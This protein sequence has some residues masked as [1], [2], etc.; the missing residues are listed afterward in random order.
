MCAVYQV[1]FGIFGVAIML[2]LGLDVI[3]GEMS[4]YEFLVSFS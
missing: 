3:N 4:I 2:P 1:Y